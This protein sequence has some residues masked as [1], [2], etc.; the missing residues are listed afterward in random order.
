MGDFKPWLKEARIYFQASNVLIDAGYHSPAYFL[1]THAAELGMKS[2]LIN[3]GFTEKDVKG[4]DE[5]KLFEDI[6]NA[7]YPPD[8]IASLDSLYLPSDLIPGTVPTADYMSHTDFASVGLV[9]EHKQSANIKYIVK[10][11]APSEYI[12]PD[13]ARKK[14][15]LCDKLL[16]LIENYFHIPRHIE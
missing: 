3:V 13:D 15:E 2:L 5:I 12:S 6:E 1:A 7:S 8:F 16:S 4:H 11:T 14:I 9:C 10:G